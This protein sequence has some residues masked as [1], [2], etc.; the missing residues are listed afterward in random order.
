MDQRLSLVTL[1]VADL[2]RSRGFYESMGWT[3]GSEPAKD[4]ERCAA[5]R[6]SRYHSASSAPA[7]VP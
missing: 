1:G 2:D 3:S 5:S 6:A 4:T 7:V